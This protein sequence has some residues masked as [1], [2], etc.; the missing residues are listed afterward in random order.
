MT[1]VRAFL[2]AGQCGKQRALSRLLPATSAQG[3]ADVPSAETILTGLTAIAN[4]WRWLAILWHVLLGALLV[5]L[6]AG[7]R[8]CLG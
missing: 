1:A 3:D 6:F 2:D 7:W 8:P 5:T 4:E